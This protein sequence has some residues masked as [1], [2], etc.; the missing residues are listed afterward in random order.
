MAIYRLQITPIKREGGHS[1]VGAAAYRAGERI[2]D[3]RTNEVHNHSR[4][5]DVTHSEIMLPA[6]LAGQNM[7]WARNRASLWNSVENAESRKNARVATEI[8]VTLPFELAPERRLAMARTFSQ[9]IADHYKVAVDLAV[10]DPR[11][12]GDPRNFHAHLL[13]TT[14]E[15]S[16]AGLGAKTGLNIQTKDRLRLGLPNISQEFTAVRERW[17]T[18]TNEAL[19]E[20]NIEARV[21]HRSLAEQGIDREPK[22][23]I[24]FAAYKIERAGK[25]SEVAEDIRADY[26]AR[27]QARLEQQAQRREASERLPDRVAPHSQSSAQAAADNPIPQSAQKSLEDIRREARENWL[28]MRAEQAAQSAPSRAVS[29]AEQSHSAADAANHPAQ[30]LSAARATNAPVHA[31]RGATTPSH[32]PAHDNDHQ[33]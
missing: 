30:A 5:K 14:R 29:A 23:H 28:K 17:A 20:A 19:E 31:S 32:T 25:H 7:E 2:R 9:E 12:S 22:P 3:D 8:Q 21:D 4:R 33:P 26:N 27:V 6:D 11:P 16:A 15:V 10:H 24:P 1:S 18:L 13:L